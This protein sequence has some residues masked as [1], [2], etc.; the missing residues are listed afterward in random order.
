MREAE[1][2]LGIVLNDGGGHSTGRGVELGEEAF[3]Q[4]VKILALNVESRVSCKAHSI[5]VTK[6]N[7]KEENMGTATL[8]PA[9]P[10]IQRSVGVS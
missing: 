8:G 10:G 4:S 3:T 5:S 7:S 9:T 2:L 1:D 6:V